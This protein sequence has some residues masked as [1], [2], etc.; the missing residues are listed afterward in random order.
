MM[1]VPKSSEPQD[2]N[3]NRQY[4]A[5]NEDNYY[6]SENILKA[7]FKLEK[8]SWRAVTFPNGEEAPNW[9]FQGR[10]DLVFNW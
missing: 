2:D 3:N 10:D 8:G 7:H 5:K 6:D 4:F 1:V 9:F